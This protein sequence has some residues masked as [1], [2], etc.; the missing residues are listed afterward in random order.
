MEMLPKK[1]PHVL[2]TDDH[3]GK[4][5]PAHDRVGVEDTSP[6]GCDNHVLEIAP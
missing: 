6:G 3:D 2:R 5:C 4:A 1:I